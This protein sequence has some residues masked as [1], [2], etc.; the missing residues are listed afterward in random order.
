MFLV[1]GVVLAVWGALL[2]PAGP[3][4]GSGSGVLLSLG[5]LF[6]AVGNPVAALLGARAL[7]ARR[8]A[9]APVAAWILTS[10]ELSAVR[11]AGS[12]I[13]VGGSLLGTD[14]LLFLGA[15]AVT[16]I[17][18]ALFVVPVPGPRNQ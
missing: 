17:A 14:S 10:L 8:G 7:A 16:G 18:A 1:L 12:I 2:V 6:A 5:V 13:L 4:I 15:G 11:P 3:R 9:V